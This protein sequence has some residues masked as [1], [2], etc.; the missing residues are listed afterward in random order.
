M[1]TLSILSKHP[2][3][4]NRTLIPYVIDNEHIIGAFGNEP[5]AVQLENGT[6]NRVEVRISI[7][8]TDVLTGEPAT[9]LATGRRWVVEPRGK[10]VLEA[11]PE[12]QQG[13]ARFLFTDSKGSVAVHTRGDARDMGVIAAAIFHEDPA[14]EQYTSGGV[15]RGMRERDY[16]KGGSPTRGGPRGSAS[17]RTQ[18]L[19][20]SLKADKPTMDSMTFESRSMAGTG[21]GEYAAQRINQVSG[22][23]NPMLVDVLR[24]RYMWWDDLVSKLKEKN[25]S[26]NSVSG[27]PGFPGNKPL[28]GIDLGSTPRKPAPAAF[29][30]DVYVR[31]TG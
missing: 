27:F 15:M 21:A 16:M 11:W 9:T 30:P 29:T 3:H 14:R 23:R 18:S 24:L 8:G 13:G 4:L 5:Y 7:D 31:V 1:H 6:H 17:V 22:L 28:K 12:T 20:T 2:E 25:I 19:E 26:P 10:L